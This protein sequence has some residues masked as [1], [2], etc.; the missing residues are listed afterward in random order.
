MSQTMVSS[1]ENKHREPSALEQRRIA[2]A[3]RADV[4]DV[5]QPDADEPDEPKRKLTRNERLQAL[6]DSGCD[7]WEE[8]RGER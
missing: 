3:L 5:F 7:T 6:A 4:A 2:K 1:I 8:F